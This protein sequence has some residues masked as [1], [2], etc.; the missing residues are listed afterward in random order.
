MTEKM[1]AFRIKTEKK[2]KYSG[3]I[4]V[5]VVVLM[6]IAGGVIEYLSKH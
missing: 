5:G 2:L 4:I 6:V 3:G 1:L